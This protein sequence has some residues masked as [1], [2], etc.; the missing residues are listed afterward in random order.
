[1]TKP[2]YAKQAAGR[3][4]QLEQRIALPMPPSLNNMF[5]NV[6]NK[7]R[8]KTE[9]YRKWTT[10]AGWLLKSQHPRK[11]DVPVSIIIE[12]NFSAKASRSDLDNR[13]KALID[14]LVEHAVIP[15]DSIQWVKKVSLEAVTEGAPCTVVVAEI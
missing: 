12:L 14:L 2:T 3:T 8:V 6:R 10:A 1:M 5:L 13:S 15:D 9:N 4:P 11:F 7:G